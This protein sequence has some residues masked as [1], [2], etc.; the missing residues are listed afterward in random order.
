VITFSS[1]ALSAA[2]IHSFIVPWLNFQSAENTAT[3]NYGLNCDLGKAGLLW[4]ST[5]KDGERGDVESGDNAMQQKTSFSLNLPFLNQS[6][7]ANW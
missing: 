1:P 3:V 5:I 7:K 6:S 4:T 2:F